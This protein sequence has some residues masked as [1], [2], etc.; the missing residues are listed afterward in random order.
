MQHQKWITF[1]TMGLWIGTWTQGGCVRQPSAGLSPQTDSVVA[2][3]Q[4]VTIP[5]AEPAIALPADA[6]YINVK[7]FGAKGDGKSDD[8]AA[9]QK[10]IG[11]G[12]GEGGR[13]F[14]S[15]YIPN[16]TYLVSNTLAWGDKKKDVIGQSRDGVIIKLKD[17]APGF[18]DTQNPK[19]ILQV[20][21]G[22]G[23]QNFNQFLRNIT[24]DSGK[25]N[26]G[27]IG[28][29]FHT[30]NG[31]GVFNVVIRSSDPQKRGHTGLSLDKA[32]PGPGLIKNVAVEGF[33]QG[34]FVTHDQYSM[35]FEHITLLKQK[36]VGFLNSWNT[37]SIRDLKSQNAVPAV[38]NRGPMSLMTL[39]DAKLLGGSP[40]V[41]AIRNHKEGALF[42][43]NIQTQGYGMAIANEAGEKRNLSGN[44]VDEF[45]SHPVATLSATGKKSLQLPIEETPIIPYGD[46]STWVNVTQFGAKPNDPQDDGAAIQKAIDSG[47]A[48]VY[49]PA[50][51]Y[52]ARRSLLVRGKVSRILGL[53]ATLIFGNEQQPA[54]V[55]QGG[56]PGPVTLE[57]ESTVGSKESVW[58]EHASKRTLLL[59]NG[60]YRNTV[61]GGKV[62]IED[63]VGSPLVF[64]R[65]K[66]WARQLNAESGQH[67]PQ[68]IN[69]G[70]DLWILGFKTE[71]DRTG[72]GTYAGGRTE[73]LGGLLYKNR[74]KRGPAPAFVVE[75]AAASLIYRNKGVP[76]R[77]QI[78]ET[79]RNTNKELRFKDLPASNGRMSLFVGGMQ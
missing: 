19:K 76:Y 3:T 77:T 20:E 24:V 42:A 49:L 38:E 28:I 57:V 72:I 48:T 63:L 74:E 12:K 13:S 41:P 78:L 1:C 52:R 6:G 21:F 29:G 39:I 59:K 43:R 4:S 50:G 55:I 64:D 10:L 61:P 71:R 70:G 9:L 62:F 47:A 27:A 23:G 54:F 44:R 56:G 69:R 17:N 11:Q 34:I 37:V 51:V 5:R 36:Q 60:S 31:G 7:Q 2:A 16:G 22:H 15:I 65:Q 32:W 33:D 40:N 67:N 75:D 58:V 35:T 53:N 14:R 68:I 45:V 25:N 8:T 30:N 79:H 46:P 66:V 18:Q 26:P 73:V